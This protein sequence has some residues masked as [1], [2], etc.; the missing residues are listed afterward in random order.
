M[1]KNQNEEYKVPTIEISNGRIFIDGKET[2]DPTLIGYAVLDYA[3]SNANGFLNSI[4]DKKLLSI[5]NNEVELRQLNDLVVNEMPIIKSGICV[6]ELGFNVNWPSSQILWNLI[7][8]IKSEKLI[9]KSE[10]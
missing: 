9:L 8:M 3:E 4:D 7:K 5:I 6:Y 2:V 10:I 1:A